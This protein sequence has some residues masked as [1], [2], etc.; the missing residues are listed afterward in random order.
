MGRR[1]HQARQRSQALAYRAA[2]LLAIG[3]AV[4]TGALIALSS[5]PRPRFDGTPLRIPIFPRLLATVDDAGRLEPLGMVIP[6][7]AAARPPSWPPALLNP[8]AR[9]R[10]GWD[11]SLGRPGAREVLFTFDDGPNPGTTDRLLPILARANIHAAFFVCGWRLESH[12]EPLRT[13]ARQLLRDTL[14]AGHVIGNHTV[15]HYQLPTLPPERVRYEIEHN[16]D[17]IEEV[18]G[19]R[20]HLFRPPYGAYSEDVRRHLV[21]KRNELWMWSIDPHDYLLVNDAEAVAQRII[22]NLGNHAGGTVLLHDTHPWSVA[23]MP[24]IIRWLER[25]N[26]SREQAGR[27]PYVV[28]D[29]A[30]YLEGARTRLPLIQAADALANTNPPRARDAG[31]AEAAVEPTTGVVGEGPVDAGAPAAMDAGNTHRRM[32]MDAGDGR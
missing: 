28:L 8:E 7:D 25:E 31:S 17:L 32:S 9:L 12:E 27:A 3:A 18:I 14:A 24:K 10:W 11:L 15:H 2:A 4:I 21:S 16:A 5:A 26:A 30:R 22:T 23:A 6:P 1:R 20:P 19:Q 29:P 13:R